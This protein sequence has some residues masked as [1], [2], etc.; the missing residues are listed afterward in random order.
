MQGVVSGQDGTQVIEHFVE[1]VPALRQWR[2]SILAKPDAGKAV[3]L[4]AFLKRGNDTL[5]ETWNYGLPAQNS[6]GGSE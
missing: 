4:R 2:L 5:S 6:V 1:Y 3:E